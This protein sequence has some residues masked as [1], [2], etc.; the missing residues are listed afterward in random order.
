MEEKKD[1]L[2]LKNSNS[3][4]LTRRGLAANLSWQKKS[5]VNIKLEEIN[6]ELEDILIAII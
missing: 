5:S 6:C 3:K 4:K 1:Y 2:Q